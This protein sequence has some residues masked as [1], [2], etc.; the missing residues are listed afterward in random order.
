MFEYLH[1]VS[2]IIIAVVVIFVAAIFYAGY[3]IGKED[4][5]WQS[6]KDKLHEDLEE[7][8]DRENK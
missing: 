1:P 4:D 5:E 2:Y 3:Q 6:I 7:L 8:L